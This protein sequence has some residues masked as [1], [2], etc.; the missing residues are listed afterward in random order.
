MAN[1]AWGVAAVLNSS[2]RADLLSA[3]FATSRSRFFS[4]SIDDFFAMCI[5][6]S[7][8]KKPERL[9]WIY[10]TN[11]SRQALQE[12]QTLYYKAILVNLSRRI[13][14]FGDER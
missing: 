3:Y 10:T 4:R 9:L 2:N 5:T 8:Y 12:C 6:F 1:L 13:G 11:S 14:V 7:I